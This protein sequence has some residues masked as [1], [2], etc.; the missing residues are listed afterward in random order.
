MRIRIPTWATVIVAAV[1]G[2]SPPD[3]RGPT[4]LSLTDD[5]GRTVALT[6]AATR[7]FSTVPSLTETLVA[8]GA[9]DALVARTPF[10]LNPAL[11][12]LPVFD[13]GSEP[14]L[15]ALA[16][17]EPDLLIAWWG[18]GRQELDGRFEAL[19]V[20]VYRAATET[21]DDLGRHALQLGVL[22]GREAAA[23][24]LVDSLD[25]ELARVAAAVDGREPIDVL[26]LLWADPPW[27]AGG[28]TFI[29]EVIELAGGRNVFGDAPGRW[30]QVSLEEI[31]RRDPDALVIAIDQPGAKQPPW[32]DDPGWR[33]LDAVRAGRYAVVEGDLFNR[34]GPRLAE[35]ARRLARFLHGAEVLDGVA[36]P[37]HGRGRPGVAGDRTAAAARRAVR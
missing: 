25:R 10:D 23:E 29:D 21:L 12:H 37:M 31:V 7:V 17:L 2:C 4:P 32:L 5:G 3:A 1:V 11:A 20:P 18:A 33:E 8:I 15:E 14:S 27:T 19:G 16:A 22:V 34:P 9:A 6:R 24:A 26:Y 30:P 36:R 28:G 35:A 13:G